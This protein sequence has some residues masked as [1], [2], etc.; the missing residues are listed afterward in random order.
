VISQ[1]RQDDTQVLGV[2]AVAWSGSMPTPFPAVG[3]QP[4]F[5]ARQLESIV[6]SETRKAH[7]LVENAA[8]R[9]ARPDLK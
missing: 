6:D 9:C 8:A 1:V 3:G 4:R 2:Q 7:K 5:S